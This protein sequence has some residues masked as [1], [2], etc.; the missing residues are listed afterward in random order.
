MC[1]DV[2]SQ[3][4][5]LWQHKDLAGLLALALDLLCDFPVPDPSPPNACGV[6]LVLSRAP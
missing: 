5:L 2:P 4:E 3:A 6:L 1:S